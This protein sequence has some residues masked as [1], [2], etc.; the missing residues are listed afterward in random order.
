MLSDQLAADG[1]TTAIRAAAAPVASSP[2]VA[3][4]SAADAL[5]TDEEVH[6]TPLVVLYGS[7]T[8]TC[9]ELAGVVATRATAAGFKT[10]V[11]SL[12]AAVARSASNGFVMPDVGGTLI[13][14][15]TYNG[16]PPDNAAAFAKWL[17]A[18]APGALLEYHRTDCCWPPL[19]LTKLGHQLSPAVCGLAIDLGPS[20]PDPP[21]PKKTQ[22]PPH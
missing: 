15:S 3:P 17:P 6:G 2:P 1:A 20:D 10:T 8:G 14:T 18:Q 4:S 19:L 16:T 13:I 5:P 11:A 9:E 12:D 22:T 7:N 21:P